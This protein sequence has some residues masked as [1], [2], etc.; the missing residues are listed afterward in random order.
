[1]KFSRIVVSLISILLITACG[2]QTSQPT[3]TVP[4]QLTET[5]S[6]S[7]TVVAAAATN[8]PEITPSPL[9]TIPLLP[10]LTPAQA[11]GGPDTYRIAPQTANQADENIARIEQKI[12]GLENELPSPDNLYVDYQP[13]YRAV[14][15]AA[16]N[17]LTH[18]PNDPRAEAWR[19]KAAHYMTLSG[20]GNDA[21]QIYTELLTSILNTGFVSVD[22][23]PKH[24]LLGNT[25]DSLYSVY[26]PSFVMQIDAISVPHTDRSFIVT[27]GHLDNPDSAT[28]ACFLLTENGGKY[29]MYFLRHSFPSSGYNI[30]LRDTTTCYTKDVTNDGVA[31]IITDSYAG[32]HVGAIYVQI[33]DVSSLPPKTMPF[34][35]NQSSSLDIWGGYLEIPA[36]K[37]VTLNISESLGFCDISAIRYLGW[38]GKWFE[39]EKGQIIFDQK[40]GQESL[41]NCQGRIQ[42]FADELALQEAI[43]VLD[44]SLKTYLSSPENQDEPLEEL[45]VLKGLYTAYAGDQENARSIFNEVTN[46]PYV[47]NSIWSAPA[48]DFLAVYKTPA[49]LYRACLKL[50][51]Y[52][53]YY[54]QFIRPPEDFIKVD[55]CDKKLALEYTIATAFSKKPID[56]IPDDLRKAG[57]QLIK[58]GRYDFDG[59]GQLELWFTV[60]QPISYRHEKTGTQLWIVAEYSQGLK[61]VFVANSPETPQFSQAQTDPTKPVIR[62]N[63]NQTF[64]LIRRPVSGEPFIS[65]QDVKVSDAIQQ[66]LAKFLQL[67]QK[68]F[69]N[70]D[71]APIYDQLLEIDQKYPNCPFKIIDKDGYVSYSYDC[72]TFYYTLAF[73]AEL[74]G[75][76]TDAVKRYYAV[77]SV[78]PDSPFAT[79]ARLK[80]EK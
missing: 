6:P 58:S 55:Q 42:G 26:M 15:H 66:D 36:E 71:P 76:D 28:A 40:P 13:Y 3:Q 33:Y 62:L 17:A 25:Q 51:G 14:W 4:A 38:N 56:E 57:I 43:D 8:P 22:D 53:K 45:H 46:S 79:L 30:I 60:I 2:S 24:I 59:N 32:G 80:L 11:V 67:R 41:F 16:W 27:L 64:E 48:K 23:L 5:A 10:T 19:W 63:T 21:I 52:S 77:W 20:E 29:S 54:T 1:M 61:A 50:V 35:T 69:S 72:A 7:P 75:K 37:P 73:S 70:N 78:Y 34:Y 65:I 74:A 39:I 18:F 12:W 68:L 31:E 9:P 49:D 44:T 47:K